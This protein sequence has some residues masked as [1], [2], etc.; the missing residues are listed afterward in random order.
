MQVRAKKCKVCNHITGLLNSSCEQC[1]SEDLIVVE[2]ENDVD[3][4]FWTVTVRRVVDTTDAGFQWEQALNA[5]LTDF[6]PWL[7]GHDLELIEVTED[8]KKKKRAGVMTVFWVF[9]P[10]DAIRVTEIVTKLNSLRP[11]F[12]SEAQIEV[13]YHDHVEV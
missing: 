6:Q 12:L 7:D 1:D 9:S 2:I 10:V 4:P 13:T 5:N 11:G 3:D 8:G